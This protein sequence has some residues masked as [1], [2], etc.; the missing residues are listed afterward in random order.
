MWRLTS[1]EPLLSCKEYKNWKCSE[2]FS[3]TKKENMSKKAGIS[4]TNKQKKAYLTT[5]WVQWLN[6]VTLYYK[7]NL[8]LDGTNTL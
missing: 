3:H 2:K 7:Y 5:Y 8:S 4:A 1:P 6:E